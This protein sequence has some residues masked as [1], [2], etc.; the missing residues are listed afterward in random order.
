[1]MICDTCSLIFY[2]R[3][4]YVEH[5]KNHENKLK[6]KLD[7]VEQVHK[8]S[9]LSTDDIQ[10]GS[11]N[12]IFEQLYKKSKLSTEDI[13]TGSETFLFGSFPTPQSNRAFSSFSVSDTGEVLN[14]E[15]IINLIKMTTL[16]SQTN[17]EI[18]KELPIY[19]NLRTD[20]NQKNLIFS[21]KF[22]KKTL[23]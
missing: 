18:T 10:T 12:A 9:K 4:S 8:T 1:M 19:P 7:K 16:S 15:N 11:G 23:Y 22:H 21:Q 17:E 20:N 3:L 2:D 13:H 6:R 14:N 5:L